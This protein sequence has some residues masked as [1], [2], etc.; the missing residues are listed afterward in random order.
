MMHQEP[1]IMTFIA[2]NLYESIALAPI[3]LIVLHVSF[4]TGDRRNLYFA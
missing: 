4:A 2:S 3:F 1:V